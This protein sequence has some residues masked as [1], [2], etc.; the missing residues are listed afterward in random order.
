M[1]TI[2]PTAFAHFL[3]LG[4]M[5]A[6]LKIFQTFSFSVPE[7]RGPCLPLVLNIPSALLLQTSCY[8]HI[9][10]FPALCTLLLSRAH[11]Q[12]Q[13][14]SLLELSEA[15]ENTGYSLKLC[16]PLHLFSPSSDK[17]SSPTACPRYLAI[18]WKSVLNTPCLPYTPLSKLILS[19]GMCR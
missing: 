13:V 19:C 3:S 9:H 11:Y 12:T 14:L 17:G 4:H 2:F 5:L 7:S 8:L 18:L 16:D 15:F 6:I 1:G 10:S